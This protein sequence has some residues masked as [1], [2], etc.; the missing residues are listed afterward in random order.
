M[1]QRPYRSVARRVFLL[2]GSILIKGTEQ[3]A[4]Q[5]S[6]AR[7]LLS[8]VRDFGYGLLVQCRGTRLNPRRLLSPVTDVS[9]GQRRESGFIPYYI[10]IQGVVKPAK[11]VT[12]LLIIPSVLGLVF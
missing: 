5:K 6:N 12:S 7:Q 11:T 9:A 10:V 1:F 8:P 3:V 4:V 2:S